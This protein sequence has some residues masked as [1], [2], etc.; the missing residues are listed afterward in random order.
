M[1]KSNK[2]NPYKK[3]EQQGQK[4]D[5]RKHANRSIR[6]DIKHSLKIGNYED[7]PEEIEIT[8]KT[9]EQ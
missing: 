2:R 6:K 7:L 5:V 9:I 8:N 3:Q 1:G 4:R